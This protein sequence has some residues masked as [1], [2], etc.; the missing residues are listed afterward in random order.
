MRIYTW[1]MFIAVL[2]LVMAKSDYK[3]LTQIVH[4]LGIDL[5]NKLAVITPGPN[6]ECL[7]QDSDMWV[8]KSKFIEYI[9]EKN[10]TNIFV[11]TAPKPWWKT[12]T[13]SMF[14]YYSDSHIWPDED[15]DGNPV[16][17][18]SLPNYRYFTRGEVVHIDG[19]IEHVDKLPLIHDYKG[20][21]EHL[22]MHP[23][24]Y[25]NGAFMDYNKPFESLHYLVQST[26]RKLHELRVSLQ[27]LCEHGSGEEQGDACFNFEKFENISESSTLS[28]T[29]LLHSINQL[30]QIFFETYKKKVVILFDDHGFFVTT[31][32]F[33]DEKYD[34]VLMKDFE[35]NFLSDFMRITFEDNEYLAKAIITSRL[36]TEESIGLSKM[37]NT[38]LIY[39]FGTNNAFPFHYV[40]EHEFEELCALRGIN[41][42]VKKEAQMEYGGY[43]GL[44]HS[45]VQVYSPYSISGFI[46]RL[47]IKNYWG[48]SNLINKVRK[49]FEQVQFQRE[50]A[51]LLENFNDDA[52]VYAD[53]G[54]LNTL[55]TSDYEM[56]RDLIYNDDINVYD[57]EKHGPIVFSLLLSMGLLSIHPVQEIPSRIHDLVKIKLRIPNGD[58]KRLLRYRR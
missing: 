18:S 14:G 2:P 30:S 53:Y 48:S 21:D 31:A 29:D 50:M 52:G 56:I 55:R 34:P 20:N 39:I 37:N 38:E 43:Y 11:I 24:I 51:P 19:K 41:E 27:I 54:T 44:Q 23:V 17:R 28:K 3:Q 15:E 26:Y 16:A 10:D 46:N 13:L 22:A 45:D 36:H 12:I 6:F 5:K 40:L 1:I 8:D 49:L 57:K 35:R 9:W 32:F 47:E 58:I 25:M 7:I 42:T 4:K 33:Q